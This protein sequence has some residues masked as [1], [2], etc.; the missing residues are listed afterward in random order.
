MA[1]KHTNSRGITYYLNSK[2]V[3]LR[4]GKEQTIFYFSKDQRPEAAD[5]PS[6]MVVNENQRNGF[7]TV[8]RK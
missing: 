5:L 8:K 2:K 6:D 1:Y 4:G 7:L 3:T